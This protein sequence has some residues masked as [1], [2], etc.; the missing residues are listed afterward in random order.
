MKSVA[1]EI[2]ATS[3]D[4]KGITF[5]YKY[6]DITR[7]YRTYVYESSDQH[8]ELES[9]TFFGRTF[10]VPEADSRRPGYSF[11]SDCRNIR[12]IPISMKEYT[13]ANTLVV[14][15]SLISSGAQKFTYASHSSLDHCSYFNYGLQ[16]R[17][18]VI[19]FK[20]MKM[21]PIHEKERLIKPLGLFAF[22]EAP[23]GDLSVNMLLSEPK[24]H[25]TTHLVDGMYQEYKKYKC[26]TEP[27]T[28][29]DAVTDSR[30]S[31]R[32]IGRV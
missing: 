24:V 30:N 26:E 18:I 9:I 25:G 27:A 1:N 3:F 11:D 12:N 31:I 2:K 21:P 15:M 14:P 32:R 17:R 29:K 28:L 16:P 6:S 13:S 4:K 22:D 23:L 5:G 19:T 10:P 20:N 7:D 8:A